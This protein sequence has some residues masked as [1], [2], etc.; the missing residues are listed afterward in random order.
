MGG[1]G[2]VVVCSPSLL[3]VVELLALLSFDLA[4]T[5]LSIIVVKLAW[6]LKVK[7]CY[8]DPNVRKRKLS[9]ED[10]LPAVIEM[11]FSRSFSRNK[12]FR[13]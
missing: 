8:N 6:N 5:T 10:C 12:K 4:S 3:Q 7:P 2:W 1:G 9:L 11:H 13:F